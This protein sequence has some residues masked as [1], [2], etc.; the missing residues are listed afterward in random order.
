MS[1][2][3]NISVKKLW[4]SWSSINY[5]VIFFYKICRCHFCQRF[6]RKKKNN[7][8]KKKCVEEDLEN[9]RMLKTA[10]NKKHFIWKCV[11]AKTKA[12]WINFMQKFQKH[13]KRHFPFSFFDCFWNAS[14]DNNM[15]YRQ[16]LCVCGWGEREEE[17][18]RYDLKM[19]NNCLPVCKYTP[20]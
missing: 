5:S 4:Y 14:C 6:D 16:T 3:P 13:S 7:T 9:W 12:E 8:W 2:I 17:N 11:S 20:L 15:Q 1:Q 10:S 19:S 18:C